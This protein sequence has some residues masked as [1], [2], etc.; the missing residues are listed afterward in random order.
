[1]QRFLGNQRLKTRSFRHATSSQH[2]CCT[3]AKPFLK[4]VIF[5]RKG[6]ASLYP[7]TK[8]FSLP[9]R[10]PFAKVCMQFSKLTLL[11]RFVYLFHATLLQRYQSIHWYLRHNS[12]LKA[13]A[14]FLLK[15]CSSNALWIL[16][17]TSL[18]CFDLALL[19][20]TISFAGSPMFFVPRR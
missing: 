9:F 2:M 8:V 10:H 6:F 12:S 4:G 19:T 5:V 7:F 17:I 11:Q 13:I 1:M 20:F 3:H 18:Y 15:W 14:P 16:V